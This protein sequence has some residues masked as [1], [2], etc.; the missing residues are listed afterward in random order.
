M[1]KIGIE[2]LSKVYLMTRADRLSALIRLNITVDL[3][4]RDVATGDVFAAVMT[5]STGQPSVPTVSRLHHT[6]NATVTHIVHFSPTK[7]LSNFFES[8]AFSSYYMWHFCTFCCRRSRETLDASRSI[9][10]FTCSRPFQNGIISTAANGWE[11]LNLT[12]VDI[13][14]MT[15]IECRS[16]RIWRSTHLMT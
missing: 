4:R 2:V 15:H 12:S 9:G 1:L 7:M 10:V 5:G 3:V 6:V 8:V 14:I 16:G 13:A 11:S